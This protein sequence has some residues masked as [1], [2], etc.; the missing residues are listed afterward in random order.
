MPMPI[1]ISENC[2][3]CSLDQIEWLIKINSTSLLIFGWCDKERYID[4]I[5]LHLHQTFY[6]ENCRNPYLEN[7]H[8]KRV[9]SLKLLSNTHITSITFWILQNQKPRGE[10][11]IIGLWGWKQY[12]AHVYTKPNRLN[13]NEFTT[14]NFGLWL[15]HHLFGQ[16]WDL[17]S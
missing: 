12:L 1:F 3:F 5:S 8:I 11:K 10:F 6:N 7:S 4:C 14:C 13:W 17:K 9:W 16:L 2:L 15:L